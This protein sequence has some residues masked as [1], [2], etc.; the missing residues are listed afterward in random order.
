MDI[1]F[2]S[3]GWIDLGVG[4]IADDPFLGEGQVVWRNLGGNLN[5]FLL[6][7]ANKVNRAFGGDMGNVQSS[8]GQLGKR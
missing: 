8:S 4:V 2:S 7:T 5:A 1:L 3:Q 6:G